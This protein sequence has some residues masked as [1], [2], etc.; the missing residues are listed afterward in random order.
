MTQS[1]KDFITRIQVSQLVTQDPYAEDFYAQVFNAIHQS[2]TGNSRGH[3]KVLSFGNS[4]G[5][6][7][8][9]SQER[10]SG[11]RENAL[12]RMQVQIERI[13]NNAKKRESA[14]HGQLF[15]SALLYDFGLRF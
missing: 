14:P 10:R 5:I 8:I 3:Q 13:V 15:R 7:I 9:P 4:G 6:G 12:N 2:R 1:D 11:R